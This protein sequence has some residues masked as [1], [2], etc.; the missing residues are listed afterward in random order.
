MFDLLL[1]SFFFCQLLHPVTKMEEMYD[2]VP[3]RDEFDAVGRNILWRHRF[4]SMPNFR[5]LV[6]ARIL[7]DTTERRRS[8]G[9]RPLNLFRSSR[10]DH[11]TAEEV[12]IFVEL[13]IRSV[14]D[15]RSAS[16]YR[17]ADGPKL[18]DA[19]YPAY[20]VLGCPFIHR[21]MKL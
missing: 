2:R 12:D 19:V 15:L 13:N 3:D 7:G 16:E 17:K 8:M 9:G 10:P 18:L 20:K 14:I 4:N 21:C 1:V 5:R 11:L 6:S